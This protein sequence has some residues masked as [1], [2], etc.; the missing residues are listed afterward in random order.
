MLRDEATICP[1]CALP[2]DKY[3]PGSQCKTCTRTLHLGCLHGKTR[4]SLQCEKCVKAEAE[5]R[6]APLATSG[7]EA[8]HLQVQLD[9]LRAMMTTMQETIQKIGREMRGT[10]STA[11]GE[12]D[13]NGNGA[14]KQGGSDMTNRSLDELSNKSKTAILASIKTNR[15]TKAELEY[16]RSSKE[17][18]TFRGDPTTWFVFFS[19]YKETTLNCGYSPRE[20][21]ERLKEALQDKARVH[22]QHY[23]DMPHRIED[24]MRELEEEFGTSEALLR[25]VMTLAWQ[26]EELNDDLNNVSAFYAVVLKIADALE[27]LDEPADSPGLTGTLVG[28]I[29]IQRG[30]EWMKFLQKRRA[31]VE[32]FRQFIGELCH[33]YLRLQGGEAPVQL[34]TKNVG[35]AAP[36]VY[37]PPLDKNTFGQA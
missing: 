30:M 37:E 5:S 31:T 6:P 26:V 33:D 14:Q 3:S 36:T 20:N 25:H 12:G 15:V 29:G 19:T 13:N 16:R 22:V 17:L 34:T 35:A 9:D 18:P 24:L 27:L 28:K 11:S 4:E 7:G 8:R 23:F 1:K 10:S 32:L 2:V 21:L